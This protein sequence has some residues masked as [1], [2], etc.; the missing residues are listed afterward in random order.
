[1]FLSVGAGDVAKRGVIHGRRKFRQR[2]LTFCVADRTAAEQAGFRPHSVLG[3]M[4]RAIIGHLNGL[5]VVALDGSGLS[6]SGCCAAQKTESENCAFHKSDPVRGKLPNSV[7]ELGIPERR[8][9][10]DGRG[11]PY[12]KPG[13]LVIRVRAHRPG[14][15]ATICTYVED[16]GRRR[17]K[18]LNRKDPEKTAA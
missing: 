10:R 18:A 6:E 14:L 11:N 8:G 16:Q 5:R 4:L 9:F 1:V 12:T 7:K 15:V 13:R 3:G 17:N 2:N